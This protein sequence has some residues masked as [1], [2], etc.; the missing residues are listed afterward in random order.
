MALTDAEQLEYLELLE[1]EV[2]Y[3]AGRKLWTYYPDAG[4]LR[5]ELY[6]KH[7][8]FFSAGRTHKQRLFLAA[9]RIG[10]TEGVGLYETVCHMTG[11]YP[12]WWDSIG[13]YRFDRPVKWWIAGTTN[14]TTRDILQQKLLGAWGDFGTGVLPRECLLGTTN[15]SGVPETV[16]TF[17]VQHHDRQGNPDGISRGAFKSYK[18]GMEAFQG[19]EQDGVLCD[20]EPPMSIYAECLTRTMTVNGMVLVTF[21]PLEG[22][23]DTVMSFLHDGQI[24][25]GAQLDSPKFVVNAGWD[26]VPH[27]TTEQKEQLLASYQPYQRD[28]RSQGLP[29]LGAGVIYPIPEEEY[30][31]APFELPKHWKRAYALDV[32]WNR[33]AALWG[34]WDSE[35]NTV[36]F[37]HEHYSAEEKPSVHAQGIKAPG[38]WIPGV[39]DPAA[40]GR[41]QMD[42]RRLMTTY[43]GL[44]LQLTTANNAVESGLYNCLEALAEGRFKVFSTLQHFFQ[45]IRLYRRDDKGKVIKVNDHLMDCMR[46]WELSAREVAK[47]KPVKQEFVPAPIGSGRSGGWMA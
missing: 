21:T 32:G 39:I 45:E 35:T 1:A 13:G 42:G 33:T 29:V 36:Y 15:K 7:L 19:T 6:P 24:P 17:S 14:E 23:S 37:Y 28:A 30:T 41:N 25:E 43:Q 18:Q 8:Q 22:L 11:L 3:R 5:R 34:A 40:R 26:D 4:P 20:E 46:Y 47:Q 16:E 12:E 2:E 10:K 27:L 44:G 9:N 38:D 31:V